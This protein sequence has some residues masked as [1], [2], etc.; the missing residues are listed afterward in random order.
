M[1]LDD[2][3]YAESVFNDDLSHPNS[4]DKNING[5]N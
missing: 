4:K 5:N 1:F 2:S 3:E